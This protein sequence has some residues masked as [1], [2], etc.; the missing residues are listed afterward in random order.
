MQIKNFIGIDVSKNTLDVSVVNAEG[1]VFYY[2]CISNNSKAI[3][4][5]FISFMKHYKI[6]FDESVFCMEYT[7]I[8]NLPL[9]KWLRTH[10]GHIWMESG[11]QINKSLGMVRGKND[12]IDSS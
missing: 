3:K 7:G 11:T 12:K 9:V 2:Q 10:Q 4:A 8:Y 6:D 1:N 5:T